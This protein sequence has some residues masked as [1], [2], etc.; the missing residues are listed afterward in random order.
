MRIKA[1]YNV[2]LRLISGLRFFTQR[3]FAA[4]SKTPKESTTPGDVIEKSIA[5]LN[6]T[7]IEL[8]DSMATKYVL[9]TQLFYDMFEAMVNLGLGS[10]LAYAWSMGFHCVV[11]TAESSCWVVLIMVALALF[12]FQCLLQ[13]LVMTGWRAKETKFAIIIGFAVFLVSMAQF[14]AG[15]AYVDAATVTAVAVHINALLLQISPS[16]SAINLNV[17][18]PLVEVA[19]SGGFA[20]VVSGLVIPALRY[21]Q[22]VET[23]VFGTRAEL[24]SGTYKTLLWLDFFLPLAVGLAFSP[25]PELAYHQFFSSGVRVCA[26]DADVPGTCTNI[27][28][29]SVSVFSNGLM[30]AQLLLAAAMLTL[31]VI[32]MKKHMQ[33]FLDSVVRLVSVHL[34]AG[35]AGQSVDQPALLARV[36]VSYVVPVYFGPRVCSLFSQ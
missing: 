1:V 27:D 29:Y 22:A 33:C 25:L 11:P 20:L 10:M 30:T 19:I 18:V 2:A 35:G 4:I 5:Q 3:R 32:C 31:R 12:S 8:D 34:M 23:L 7:M 16:I 24:T 17:L 13:I 14:L 36:R 21:S 28:M 6:L 9:R 15:Y 26:P